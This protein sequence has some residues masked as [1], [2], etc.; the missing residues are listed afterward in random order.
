MRE[1]APDALPDRTVYVRTISADDLPEDVRAQTDLTTLY[2]IHA[3]TGERI[4]I[5]G[6][7]RLA[8]AVARQ[9]E[10]APVSVH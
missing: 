7:R 9:H 2:A 1:H 5:V 4:A 6:D 8:F 3:E 10:M